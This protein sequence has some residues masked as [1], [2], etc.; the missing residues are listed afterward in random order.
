MSLIASSEE[1]RTS[2]AYGL[3]FTFVKELSHLIDALNGDDGSG[4]DETKREISEAL[5]ANVTTVEGQRKLLS[6]ARKHHWL[7]ESQNEVNVAVEDGIEGF[8]HFYTSFSA[9]LKFYVTAVE[10]NHRLIAI[11]AAL[12]RCKVER[13]SG[14]FFIPSNL[15]DP[16]FL[17]KSFVGIED[18]EHD[19][20][21]NALEKL[22]LSNSDAILGHLFDAH[23]TVAS[24][25]ATESFPATHLAE[26]LLAEKSKNVSKKKTGSTVLNIYRGLYKHNSVTR[27]HEDWTEKKVGTNSKIVSNDKVLSIKG[28]RA[29]DARTFEEFEDDPHFTDDSLTQYYEN[30]MREYEPCQ[31]KVQ[32]RVGGEEQN[33][34]VKL[35]VICDMDN[36]GSTGNYPMTVEHNMARFLPVAVAVQSLLETDGKQLFTSKQIS[37]MLAGGIIMPRSGVNTIVIPKDD[38]DGKC[39]DTPRLWEKSIEGIMATSV[40]A[41]VYIVESAKLFN[42]DALLDQTLNAFSIMSQT[43]DMANDLRLSIGKNKLG[44]ISFVNLCSLCLH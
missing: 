37:A 31:N 44:T 29:R 5:T 9:A 8:V 26:T 24:K 36:F 34:E 20:M 3:P 40:T 4:T 43:K 1:A 22:K 7:D 27:D 33:E 11:M 15:G 18:N 12:L 6:A 39:N 16:T 25:T 35:P 30:P 32:L 38:T 10:G 14:H 21:E 42:A 13:E 19:A 23:I 17:T 28:L 41:L 2:V